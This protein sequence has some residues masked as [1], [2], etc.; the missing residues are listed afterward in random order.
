MFQLSVLTCASCNATLSGA[1]RNQV[2]VCKNCHNANEI[3]KGEVYPVNVTYALSPR[4]SADEQVYIPFW[5]LSTEIEISNIRII[6]GK[7]KRFVKGEHSFDGKHQIWIPAGDL[8]EKVAENLGYRY[9]QNYPEY[10]EGKTPL[11]K[12]VAVSCDHND[13]MQIA[14]Y[15]FLKHEVKRSGTLQSIDYSITYSGYELVYLPF[16]KKEKKLVPLL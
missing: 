9:S 6:G 5:V 10:S 12:D 1:R 13:A 4:G 11:I 3:L 15:I 7:I 2:I 16:E 8:P 14:E